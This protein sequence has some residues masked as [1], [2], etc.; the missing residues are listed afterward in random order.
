MYAAKSLA[1]QDMSDAAR[2]E[3][4][5]MAGAHCQLLVTKM[6]VRVNILLK[7]CNAGLE[8]VKDNIS[9]KS[10]VDICDTPLSDSA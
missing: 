8:K 6:T 10:F 5:F 2:V 4:L 7:H 1:F 3:C 9:F